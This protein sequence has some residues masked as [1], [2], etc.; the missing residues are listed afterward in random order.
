LILLLPANEKVRCPV[1]VIYG[2]KDSSS[3]PPEP[4]VAVIRRGLAKARN[5]D[6]TVK[7]FRNA[8][9]ALCKAD[10]DGPPHGGQRAKMRNEEGPDLVAGY[11]DTMTT[12]LDE[13][14]H[15]L[16]STGRSA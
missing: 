6:V 8:D 2:D 11:L 9:H 7:L 4:L 14:A 3:G 10:N 15:S 12:W 1:L 13:V 5:R 16:E